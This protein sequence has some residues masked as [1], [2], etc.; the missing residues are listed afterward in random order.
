MATPI[1]TLFRRLEGKFGLLLVT[2]LVALI[3]PSFITEGPAARILLWGFVTLVLLAGLVSVAGNR[4][5]LAIGLATALPATALGW[6]A[7]FTADVG[8][9][10]ASAGLASLFF[11]FLTVLTVLYVMRA[12]RVTRTILYGALSAYLLMGFTWGEWYA[13][14]DALNPGAIEFMV[15]PALGAYEAFQARLSQAW[16]FS[17]VTM[18][19]LGYGD[20]APVA[21]EARTLAI[22]QAVLGQL[23]LVVMVA[24][25]VAL[26]IAYESS[27]A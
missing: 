8:T 7:R 12:R 2:L 6:W 19:T 26:N 21:T 9:S 16:Y 18:T 4:L 13:I 27:D 23:Y 24:R 11:A 22:V 3:A 10:L 17:F 15:D 1:V 5:H 14:T 25:L 20:I